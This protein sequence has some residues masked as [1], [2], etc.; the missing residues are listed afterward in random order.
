METINNIFGIVNDAIAGFLAGFLP[1]WGVAAIEALMAVVA[2]LVVL[3]LVV[4]YQ[5]LAE[6]KVIGR[7]Q[8]RYGPNRV[9]KFGL[10][11]PIADVVKLLMK[12]DI[13]PRTADRAVFFAAPII[14]L[15]PSLLMFTVIPFGDG[16][17]IADINIGLLFILAVASIPT[18]GIVVAGW[19]SGNKYSVLGGMRA[20]AQMVSFEIPLILALISPILIVGSLSMADIVNAQGGFWGLS[21][22]I[23]VQPVAFVV[24]FIAGIAEVN[25][26]PFDL[27]EAESELVAGFHTEYSGI[28]FALFFLAEYMAAFAVAA[29]AATV[30]LGGWQGPLLPPYLWFIIKAFG[31]FIVMIWIRGTLPRLR[32]DQM[33]AFCWKVLVPVALANLVITALGI[34][35][36]PAIGLSLDQ[37]LMVTGITT[38]ILAAIGLIVFRSTSGKAEGV[39]QSVPVSR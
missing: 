17:A 24:Y 28:R 14:V 38:L 20:A 4:M 10:L 1:D 39:G 30:F 8:D 29:I 27:P 5:T 15:I 22:L 16:L 2:V 6:R 21:W 19:G 37:A 11:Q 7:I 18:I 26:S 13:R 36:L 9:G 33:M 12:E 25:R 32:I 3:I 35:L 34:Q 31:L 23:F